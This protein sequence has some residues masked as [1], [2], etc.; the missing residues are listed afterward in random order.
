MPYQ[1]T[2]NEGTFYV[3]CQPTFEEQMAYLRD[4]RAKGYRLSEI[5]YCYGPIHI[6]EHGPGYAMMLRDKK[7]KENA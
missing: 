6:M 3:R 4:K 7:D 5:M 1:L 2:T